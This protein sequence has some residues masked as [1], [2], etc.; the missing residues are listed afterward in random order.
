[1]MTLKPNTKY[2]LRMIGATSL[3]TVVFAIDQHL[4]TVVEVDGTVVK[5]K[6]NL[7]SIA[8]A[9][10]QRYAVIIETRNRRQG[11]FLMITAI[12]WRTM[13]NSSR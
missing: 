8:I 12:R 11:V 7:S 2:L 10:G 6:S 13:P 9:S 1:V 4:M 5:P 3:S